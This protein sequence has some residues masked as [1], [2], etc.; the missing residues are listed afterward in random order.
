MQSSITKQ[1]HFENIDSFTSDKDSWTCSLEKGPNTVTDGFQN[2]KFLFDNKNIFPIDGKSGKTGKE[3]VTD[4]KIKIK[5][6]LKCFH[7]KW[8]L[9]S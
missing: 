5:W 8:L 6:G 2:V 4:S 1:Q 3:D 9:L 7:S